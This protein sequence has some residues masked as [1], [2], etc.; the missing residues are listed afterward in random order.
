MAVCDAFKRQ[1]ITRLSLSPVSRLIIRT[2]TP[3]SH[4]NLEGLHSF[5]LY[6]IIH[7]AY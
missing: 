2:D 3:R 1:G 5:I 4:G 7:T 6:Y